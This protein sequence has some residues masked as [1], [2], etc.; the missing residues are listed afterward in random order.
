MQGEDRLPIGQPIC[1]VP[2][3][4]SHS[5]APMLDIDKT[6]LHRHYTPRTLS[7]RIAYG[8]VGAVR[9]IARTFARGRYRHTAIVMETI[10]AVPG[11]VAATQLHLRCLRR[12]VD[13][14]GWIRAL[15]SEAE[16]QRTHLMVFVSIHHPGLFGRLSVLLAQGVFYNAHF[17][18]YLCSAGTAHRVA[19]YF[20]EIAVGG[21]TS[22]LEDLRTGRLQDPP[23]PA[24]AID[25]WSLD[26]AAHLSDVIVAMREDEAISRDLNHGFADALQ[27]GSDLPDLPRLAL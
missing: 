19:G 2:H 27:R 16:T 1:I 13:D 21:Y 23:A 10:A 6:D 22:Y 18:L 17:L 8:L 25:Y 4:D 26:P 11:M 14:R 12:M 9:G 15:M 7:D 20:A 5:A 24:L 3:T